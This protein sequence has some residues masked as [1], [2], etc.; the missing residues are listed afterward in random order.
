MARILPYPSS[1]QVGEQDPA[2]AH[3]LDQVQ[4]RALLSDDVAHDRVGN[5]GAQLVE[6]RSH[7]LAL[8]G[9]G[10]ARVLLGPELGDDRIR[11]RRG[12]L[13]S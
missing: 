3:E 10:V 12:D 7:G 4:S 2:L 9:L 11:D 5:E 8:Q 13:L 1:G 6:G